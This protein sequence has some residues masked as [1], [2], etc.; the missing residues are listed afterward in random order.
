M[1]TKKFPSDLTQRTPVL[2]TDKL[3]IHNITTGA[4]EY[5]T[6][7]DLLKP[8][9]TYYWTCDGTHFNTRSPD[10]D[11]LIKAST[12]LLRADQDNITAV[13]HIDLP[14]GAL[15]TGAIIYGNA[16][17][18]DET[19]TLRRVKLSDNAGYTMGTENINTEQTTIGNARVDNSTF[20]YV[21]YTSGI[22]TDDEIY[23]AR[24]AYTL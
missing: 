6:V 22:D 10:I 18:G 14:D 2:L 19:F 13:A 8:T 11:D 7:A 5:C 15:I 16:A 23:G 20:A 1:A 4:T 17:A 12:G 9:K 21:I 24:I 3:L